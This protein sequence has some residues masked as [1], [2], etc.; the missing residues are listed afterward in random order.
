M[1]FHI[2]KT[3]DNTEIRRRSAP[4][5]LDVLLGPPL[6]NKG[7]IHFQIKGENVSQQPQQK[8]LLKNEAQYYRISSADQFEH[9][10]VRNFSRSQRVKDKCHNNRRDYD[11]QAK[12]RDCRRARSTTPFKSNSFC[13]SLVN[14]E[15]PLQPDSVAEHYRRDSSLPSTSRAPHLPSEEQSRETFRRRQLNAFQ[16]GSPGAGCYLCPDEPISKVGRFRSSRIASPRIIVLD[17]HL[18]PGG[19]E[20]YPVPCHAGHPFGYAPRPCRYPFPAD[21]VA[22]LQPQ[23]FPRLSSRNG[24]P[25]PASRH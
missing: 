3:E 1:A 9:C 18:S 15:I 16:H 8:G 14:T 25:E 22:Q 21:L 4:K 10:Y 7:N 11:E 24:P 20:S 12:Q 19:E 13:S 2:P 6:G 17:T 23:V 5:G